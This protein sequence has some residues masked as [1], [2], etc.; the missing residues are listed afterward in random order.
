MHQPTL[1]LTNSQLHF[2]RVGQDGVS[3]EKCQLFLFALKM[4]TVLLMTLSCKEEE[5]SQLSWSRG[6][7]AD[8]ESS[9][10]TR[11][12]KHLSPSSHGNRHPC[13]V[14]ERCFWNGA[15]KG[16]GH[17]CLWVRGETFWSSHELKPHPSFL[18]P[19]PSH[20]AQPLVLIFSEE[21][22]SRVSAF[23]IDWTGR[24]DGEDMKR[25]D[26]KPTCLG[27]PA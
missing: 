7:I 9:S 13:I 4:G 15:G 21:V 6:R 1:G 25:W 19:S 3:F 20:F 5:R 16:S 18:L 8:W 10:H 17:N 11:F 26:G 24:G 14:V 27:E 22:A 12:K 23:P 2:R